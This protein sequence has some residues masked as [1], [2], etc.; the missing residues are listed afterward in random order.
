M[1]RLILVVF[2]AVALALALTTCSSESR[3]SRLCLQLRDKL[4]NNFGVPAEKLNCADSKWDV[5][6]AACYKVFKDE[7][8]VA[9][10][11]GSCEAL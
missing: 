10:A 1:K 2:V 9:V 5:D 3:C 4:M 6:C 8:Q 7:L 11:A